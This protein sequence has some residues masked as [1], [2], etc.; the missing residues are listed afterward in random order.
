MIDFTFTEE[1]ELLRANLRK[2]GEEEVAPRLAGMIAAKEIPAEL[3]A[4]L[5][6]MGL[7]GMCISPRYGGSG[8]E[9][10]TAGVVAE[11]LGR[12]DVGCAIPTFFLV[13][14]A[15]SYLLDRYGSEEVKKEVFPRMRKG[16]A[17]VGIGVTEPDAGSD[18]ASA[19]TVAVK[20][21]S[22]Y[23]I[24]G[25][26]G[27]IS[28]VR[29]AEKYGGGFVTLARTAPELGTRGMTLFF[30]PIK[31]VPGVTTRFTEELGREGISWGGFYMDNVSVPGHYRI[32]DENKGFYLV[33]EGFEFAR[34]MIAL[35]CVG[36]ATRALENATGYMKQRQAFGRAIARYEGLQ[37]ILA[38]DYSKLEAARLLAYKAL[39]MYHQ[40]QRE[41]KFSR[42]QVSQAVAMAKMLA[43]LWAF[44][45]ANH[46]MQ[47]QGAY[48]YSMDCPEQRALRGIRSYTLAEGSTEVM[49]LI[50]TRELLGREYLAY[51]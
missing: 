39:W 16:E 33:N 3:I 15:W 13:Q 10:V 27:Y 19:R 50:V 12:A 22:G 30:F 23:V 1:Q 36:A 44:D 8:L 29:E 7:L 38:E 40:E 9:A 43:P 47:W 17:F 35:V 51:R 11:E 49:K 24:S 31:G 5:S 34:G 37:F 18:V 46:A 45:A 26:K 25:E 14:C 21:G 20:K 41:G 48:G 28:G 42:F 6:R 32:G 4:G 2:F